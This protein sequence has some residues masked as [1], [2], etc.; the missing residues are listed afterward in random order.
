MHLLL[1]A[2]AGVVMG[3]RTGGS[4]PANRFLETQHVETGHSV[5]DL[6]RV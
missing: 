6:A 3:G 4:E 5:A 2:Q 1:P